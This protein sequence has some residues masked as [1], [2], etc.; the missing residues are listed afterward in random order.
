MWSMVHTTL[1]D[2]SGLAWNAGSPAAD[3]K[4]K[5]E[6]E[7]LAKRHPQFMLSTYDTRSRQGAEHA[8][9]A[10][11]RCR[12]CGGSELQRV[13]RTGLLQ[14]VCSYFC[15]FPYRCAKCFQRQMLIL[16]SI[17]LV[18]P[19]VL[20][21]LLAGNIIPLTIQLWYPKAHAEVVTEAGGVAR[22]VRTSEL[23]PFERMMLTKKKQTM[24]NEDVVLL[25]SSGVDTTLV[26]KM[27]RASN[28]I[29]DLSP[30]AV[31]KLKRSNVDVVVIEAMIDYSQNRE[32]GDQ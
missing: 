28:G 22:R 11:K 12:K 24:R 4:T 23:T 15:A 5:A 17:R 3:V 30:A 13:H 20:I 26:L 21:L 7:E 2:T 32:L 31:V 8:A 27:I 9:P 14:W 25:L 1:T 10:G 19:V 6:V 29:Y 18:Q 16:P